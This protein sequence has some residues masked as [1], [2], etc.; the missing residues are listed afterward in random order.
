MTQLKFVLGL[1]SKGARRH[2]RH[3]AVIARARLRRKMAFWVI[4]ACLLAPWFIQFSPPASH[5]P[6]ITT[7][8]SSAAL[9]TKLGSAQLAPTP[10]VTPWAGAA[11]Q[12]DRDHEQ[13]SPRP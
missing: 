13:F 11:G 4:V 7:A 12:I 2:P 1:S 6:L 10:A 3:P 5:S 8:A 9:P